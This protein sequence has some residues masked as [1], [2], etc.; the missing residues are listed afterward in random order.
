MQCRGIWLHLVA[1]EKSHGFSQVATGTWGIFSN[2]SGD[3]H[4]KL[5]FLQQI[6]D[7]CLG[8]TDSSAM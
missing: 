5:E 6:Q 4:S 8:K 7:T 1:R 2:Y 3:V